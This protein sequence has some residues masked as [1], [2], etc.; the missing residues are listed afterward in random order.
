MKQRI[1]SLRAMPQWASFR[2]VAFRL[3]PLI[4]L[5]VAL[6]VMI[7]GPVSV[8]AQGGPELEL[9]KT[10]FKS[11]VES[12]EPFEYVFNYRCA[13]ISDDCEGAVITDPLPPEVEFV[14][15]TLTVT[16]HVASYG[17]D[18]GTHTV[19]WTFVDPL[20]A[21]ST[22]ILKFQV[23]FPPGT[24]P[25]TTA[26][27]TATFSASNAVSVATSPIST[28]AT[29]AFEMYAAKSGGPAVVGFPA[30]FDLQVCSPDVEGGV[31]YTAPTMIDHLPDDAAFVDAEGSQCPGNSPPGPGD[32]ECW[33]YDSTATPRTV[34]WYNL[35]DITVGACFTR[36]I[37]LQYD[38][39]PAG[40]QTNSMETIGTPEGCQDQN[41]LPD[42]C[43]GQ[44][45]AILTDTLPFDVI[46]PY[47]AGESGKTS[48]SPSSYEG[49]EAIPGEDV[50]YEVSVVNTGYED[51]HN[52]VVTDTL[53]S[54]TILLSLT[55]GPASAPGD[56]VNGY[57]Q[58]DDSGNW[59]PL[60][61]NP[62][63]AESTIDATT[64]DLQG[65]NR[66]TDLQWQ[67]GTL[68]I[69]ASWAS[70]VIAEVDTTI[71][72][73]YP[74]ESFENCTGFTSDN[75]VESNACSAVS[76]IDERAI[77]RPRKTSGGQSVLPEGFVDFSVGLNN[78]AVAQLPLDNPM[79]VDLLPPEFDYVA[80]SASV[81]SKPAGAPDPNF[82]VIP[83]Y[84]GTGRTLLRWTWQD[85]TGGGCDPNS[86]EGTCG[87]DASYSFQPGEDA[88][89]TFTVQVKKGTPP[90]TVTNEATIVDWTGP[91]DPDDPPNS[92]LRKIFLCQD[93]DKYV[94]VNDL[95]GDGNTFEESCL[96]TE[97]T[98]VGVFLSMDSEKWVRGEI[99]CDTYNDPAVCDDL[100]VGGQYAGDFNKLGLTMPGERVDYLVQT[101][102]NSNV[103]VT[104]LSFLDITPYIGD[105]GVIDLS[106]RLSK[107]R[108]NL[109]EEVVDLV[110]GI[111]FT[112]FYSRASNPCRPDFVPSLDE[113]PNCQKPY[114]S[115]TL[116]QNPSSVQSI[117]VDFCTYN[118]DGTVNECLVLQPDETLRFG[119]HM[120]APADAPGDPSCLTPADDSFDPDANPDCQ[121]AWNSFGF[122]AVEFRDQDNDGQ[123]DP[124]HL[125]LLPSEPLKVGIRVA[126]L[127][128]NSLGDYTWL[129][130]AGIENDGIQQ[131]VEQQA[132]WGVNGVRVELWNADTDAFIDY[133]ITGPDQDGKPG[134]Y[135]FTDLPDGN[136]YLRF[137]P[138]SGYTASPPNQGG[139]DNLDSDGE[140]PGTDATYGDYYQT[141]DIS[142]T[143]NVDDRS[144]D[145]GMYRPTD[146][147]DA[148][149]DNATDFYPTNAR[150]LANAGL[151]PAD[152]ARH[153][154]KNN[155]HMGATV[156][157]EDDGF[158]EI[159][160]WG[161]DQNQTPDDE[162]GVTFDQ[163]LG[164]PELPSA[165][166]VIGETSTWNVT[167]TV[168]DNIIL[169]DAYLNAWLDFNGDGDWNDAGEQIAADV[170]AA[171]GTT[172][173]VLTL[174]IPVPAG[175]TPGTTHARFRL[176]YKQGLGPT[177]AVNYGEVEDYQVQLINKPEKNLVTTSEAHTT[178]P[179][180]TIGEIVRYKLTVSVPEGDLTNF[181][182]TDTLP[183]GLQFLDDN[184]AALS[185][186]SD[187]AMTSTEFTISGGPFADGVDPIFT[188]GT[189]T[190]SDQDD[191]EEFVVIEFNALVL[192]VSGNAAGDTLDNSFRVTFDS[193]D[194]TS[195]PVT[196]NLVEP[197]VSIVKTVTTLPPID[198][199]D[200]VTYQLT[201]TND[202]AAST[203]FDLA[204]D[205]ILDANLDLTDPNNVT[206]TAPAY[207]AVTNNSDATA[208]EV[209]LLIDKLEPGDQVTILITVT[210][211]TSVSA[212][213][214][215]PN[216]ADLAYTS[217]PGP[218]GTTGNPTGSDTPG[219]TD[220]E[221][222]ERLYGPSDSEDI[223]I[224]SPQ[225]DKL[226]PSP[227][228]YA[229]GE[230]ISYYIKVTL[231]EGTTLDMVVVD[232]LPLGLEYQSHQIITTAA[233]SGGRLGDDFNG[234]LPT[235]TVT[236]PGGSG[237]DVT[238]NFGN[239]V[240]TA[241]NNAGNNSF[242]IEIIARVL[243]IPDNS[244]GDVRDNI[245]KLQY[246]NPNNQQTE[247]IT[248]TVA[249][250]I[251]EPFL[252]ITKEVISQ[253]DPIGP[254]GQIKYR[255]TIEH[256][257]DSAMD[258]YGVIMTDTLP[259]SLTNVQVTSMSP[260]LLTWSYDPVT[261]VLRIPD[262]GSFDI[263]LGT[264]YV[265]EYTADIT[266][267]LDA[268][269]SIDNNA[270]ITWTS[271][272]GDFP[273]REREY[274]D[275]DVAP[276][277]VDGEFGDLPDGPYPTLSANNG[278]RH[279]IPSGANPYFLGAAVDA[280]PDGQPNAAATG[281]DDNP[282]SGTDDED[283][284]TFL[285]PII[286]GQPANVQIVANADGYLHGWFDFD[287]DGVLDD[288]LITAVDGVALGSPTAMRDYPVTAG[289][290]IY[291]FDAP[292]NTT[293]LDPIYSR[294]RFTSY[295][296]A[297]DPPNDPPG[298]LGPDGL[299]LDGEVE[300]YVLM[301]LGNYVWFDE[302]GNGVQDAG[303]PP[304]QDVLVN[305]LDS[306]GNPVT[307]AAGAPIVTTTDANGYYNFGG[308]P[309]G[310]YIVEVDAS[311]WDAGNVFGAGGLYPDAY[312]SPGQGGDD[313]DNTDDNGDNDGAAAIGAGVRSAPINLSPGQEPVDED[314]QETTSN[315]NSDL[316]IDFGFTLPVSVGSLVWRDDNAN[317]IQDA[318]EPPIEGATVT[319]LDAA[320]NSV[321]T[322]IN[323]N[324]ITPVT[325]G[326]DGVYHFTDL[327]QGEYIIQVQ[328]PAGMKPTPPQTPDPD[329]DDNADSNI[330]AETSPG[331]YRSDPVTLSIGGEPT[332]ETF[333]DGSPDQDGKRDDS[334]N[335]TVDFGFVQPV[336]IGSLVWLDS[337]LDGVQDVGESPIE[338]AIVT[339]LDS[340]GNPVTQDLD[341]NAIS[342]VTTAADG[343][344]NFSNLPPGDYQ[345]Q[346]QPPAGFRPTPVQQTN[347]NDDVNTDSNIA[348]EPNPGV[349]VSGIVSLLGGTE[350]TGET[351]ADGSPDQDG[352]PDADG[353]MTVDFGFIRPVSVG[354][355]VW[356]DLNANGLQD[357]G[358][359]GVD[360]ATVTLLDSSGAPVT[361]DVDGN[362]INPITTGPDG[363]YHFVNLPPGDYMVEVQPPAGYLPTPPQVADPNTDDNA[364]SN[365]ATEPS[366]G[367]YRSGVVSLLPGA[368][369][370]GE[371]FADGSPDQ[372]GNPDAD[373]NMTLDFG[374]IRPVSLGSLVWHDANGNGVQDAGEPGIE[375]AT[376]HLLDSAGNPVNDVNGNPVA[377]VTTGPDGVYHF[378]N[379]MPGDYMVEVTPPA[380]Y[381]PTSP[382]VTN[383]NND[384][385]ADSNI[386]TEPTP[387]V[388]RSDLITLSPGTE[389]VDETF[390]DGGPDQ[391]GNPDADGNMTLDF[392]F[393]EPVS[394]GS[395]VWSD[396]NANGLQDVG[397]PGIENATVSL[398]NAD[399]TPANDIDGNPVADVT[400]GTDGVYHFTN[401][402][403][404]DYI[405]QVTPPAGL[406]PTSPQVA[407]PNN[408]DNADSNIATESSP[409][410][411][412][413]GVVTLVNG[414]E[415]T[416]ETFADGSPDQ[417]GNPD[418]D[419]NMTVD[420][421]F[422]EP[423]SVGSL[424]WLDLNA[425]GLQDDGEPGVENATVSLVDAA[426]NP[427]TDIDGNPVAD[428]TTGPDGVYH[429]TNLAPGDYR[430]RVTPPAGFI[431]TPP[432]VAD[433][434]NDDNADSNIATEPSPGQYESGS[435]TLTVGG[436]PT[437]ELFAD[438][439]PD[440]DGNPDASGN[441]TV[442][443]GFI[444]PVSLGSFVW[445]DSNGN[446]VQDA[447][448]P[449]IEN[450]TVRLLDSAGNPVNDVN[451]N[452]VADVTTGPDGVYHFVN[453]PPGDYMVEV[454][455][456]AGYSPTSP[457]VTNP[458]NDD[459]ADSNI[460]TE[461]SAGVYRSGVVS[462][463]PGA[464]PT[465][466]TFADGGPDQDGNPDADGNM[467][468]DFGFIEPVSLG[469][470]VWLDENAN[471]IQDAG[472][473]P[474]ENATV[475]LLFSDG[476]PATDM[477]GNPVA[478]V[479][480][481]TDGVYHF[482][483]LAPGDYIVQVTPPPGYAPT[484]SQTA[485]PNTDD[486]SDSN[487][488]DEPTPGVYAS[489]VVTLTVGGEPT[490][491]LF[492]DGSPDQDG[493]PDADGNMTVDFGFVEV[494]SVGSLV[495]QDDNNNGIQDAG[496]PPIQGATVILLDGAGNPITQDA[497]G[498]PINPVTTG[499]DGV[500]NFANLPPGDYII[501]VS[502]PAG[503]TPSAVQ[504]PDP[505]TDD[506]TD[507]NIADEPNPGEFRSGVVTLSVGGEPT[508][509]NF[510]DGSPDQDGN[511]DDSGNMTVDFGFVPTANLGSLGDLVWWDKNH[512][513]IQDAG[514]PGIEGVALTL[515]DGVT[516]HATTDA[517]GVYTFTDLVADVYTVTVDASNFQAGGPLANWTPSPAKVGSDDAVDSDG[518]ETT[519]DYSVTL[520]AG[521][522]NP[523]IDFG[524]YVT[525]S[526]TLT[527]K[528]NTQG[529]IR[530][531]DPISFT[532]AITNTGGSWLAVLPLTDTYDTTYL[533]YGANGNYA[534][535]PSDD[536]ND[537]GQ[538]DWSDLTAQVGDIAP[539]DTVTV[540]VWFTT[541]ADT[542]N[543]PDGLTLNTA[544]ASGVMADADGPNGPL[545]PDES[546]DAIQGQTSG[547]APVVILKP[548]GLFVVDFS[549]EVEDRDVTLNWE[550]VSELNILGFQVLRQE[551]LGAKA[552]VVQEAFVPARWS[553]MDHGGEYGI[554]AADLAPGVY[555]YILQAV[556]MDG[557]IVNEG[558][559][560]ITI[561]SGRAAHR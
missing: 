407:D 21:G 476:S 113:P 93:P 546:L 514:E 377:D 500:Y 91:T 540:T 383:P 294:F 479:T 22:G 44:T 254:G 64:L 238:F 297:S 487:I 458:N 267:D 379:L 169:G 310:D 1:R 112:V 396:L 49:T 138:P 10:A 179:D 337:N 440:Q 18:P 2:S 123:N 305:L 343:L 154:L 442:D 385:N 389:P 71:E 437:G 421:G 393:I 174:N 30:T 57:Y 199:G 559:V 257:A 284:V 221:T 288:I 78:D 429:F 502:P 358:E 404:G 20:P 150:D 146:Y 519:H 111:P 231:P 484:P 545:P 97:T 356:L 43:D 141:A 302:N 380:G 534:N 232:D 17:Y 507:S 226:D 323:G 430:V 444:R 411:Y 560:R 418:A 67:L 152:A 220:A 102:N 211:R 151:E 373:G 36:Q 191:N 26:T 341:G 522:N 473:T 468:V 227:T 155:L 281:D 357:D 137:F 278:A 101:I 209:H 69:G 73:S 240:T 163:Y 322:D 446:G 309:P 110:G 82:E 506:N 217:L 63:A 395:L 324:A 196:V 255:V 467:T 39:L 233:A 551:G 178:D 428:V 230:D 427:V 544:T 273:G 471:G 451:G 465:G 245:G 371:T 495:W 180:L 438:G 420:F 314:P 132:A 164:T 557:R 168:P 478:D 165:I 450:A 561:R 325:T 541:L 474:V 266:S 553:G 307:D 48:S 441:M 37:K 253:S 282:A 58:V 329:N 192:N 42:Y 167:V 166:M 201:L 301:S 210:V 103:P 246:T 35:P 55:I 511:R 372:D 340:A 235:P 552:E 492:A 533:S 303:E 99:D 153:V 203:A 381:S 413:S 362:P 170:V 405:V 485:D 525:S 319:L 521:E 239:T 247:T 489:G 464:E 295:E 409:G 336:S 363:I 248:D 228:D 256:T 251:I 463:L 85:L 81:T 480:T 109:Q 321:T 426:G 308:L 126:P 206:W 38:T 453:L 193:F 136:Y 242:L 286:P 422:I 510:A 490:G 543:E 365:I 23:R 90:G 401:L 259:A 148:P 96:A 481:G 542:G 204:V 185:F 135:Q 263:P 292:A 84:N 260:S 439:S 550:T 215:I 33:V 207:A 352:N 252:N 7:T 159:S 222:G 177:G 145:F 537:D 265:I 330:A 95:D 142:L 200:E 181:V 218:N 106:P 556:L 347:P 338:G 299:A 332:G 61:G 108:P 25:G 434:N 46:E 496:E 173:G 461:P 547:D 482:T 403:P 397:E 415:P 524:F 121:I 386:A 140:I 455:P 539:G 423:V 312:G 75:G 388:Y 118:T 361:Q 3:I 14:P 348:S 387:G 149:F 12:G 398:L 172:D 65:G 189:V 342:P 435:V 425:N 8:S 50:T 59:I 127:R 272:D 469:S 289:S 472:E 144:W 264:T 285:T 162:D 45:E 77:P 176:S 509:E 313:Q 171:Q 504:Q 115:T 72:P 419:G 535:P 355:L 160:A 270:V 517:N 80:G 436:E 394:L 70:T 51:L 236:A 391:D 214:I 87:V 536:N 187:N 122:K 412:R 234:A 41:N 402:A 197:A 456:P 28:T 40:Q 83:D 306:A 98:E 32:P 54:Q 120:T 293:T 34:S 326:A 335:M 208:D 86:I 400:T 194:Y 529:D 271:M 378:T 493:N 549:A 224:D 276:V 368:E 382:Q 304:I 316:T 29:G 349:Y 243:D 345:V 62:Y 24:V 143:G 52:V 16:P 119:W 269:G 460:A 13:S 454:T 198:A 296:T 333:A 258:A 213:E 157:G 53:P 390:A 462:L 250:N 74:A 351:F 512:D 190:N 374:F 392:G 175:A 508:G 156:D 523:N 470:L 475:S 416:G 486:N 432:Q 66:I 497:S 531:G 279:L 558:S 317:G 483:N 364:D 68:A 131:P 31:N 448:E 339:L 554:T 223:T 366:A 244:N 15:D 261:G 344:Y 331:V 182:I 408:D 76:V 104:A 375:N 212:G 268:G 518:D 515:T 466:E 494:V 124:D 350:P 327:P 237:G 47:P 424:V 94:D 19:T 116:P 195:A 79:L 503:F 9:T 491:E 6:G 501:Q 433:P 158:P 4:V 406:N 205:D 457:Q 320:G 133:K 241:D 27:N 147:S 445:Q 360:G 367:V 505:N 528:L 283:G 100:S 354:S 139:D 370:T 128:R 291:T 60:P 300:D 376:V 538:I 516:L 216:T 5:L 89:I 477:D 277:Q 452:P 417:D 262:T 88:N 134:Y 532:I 431:P 443:F 11:E 513:G 183:A 202:G 384:D 225:V 488:A 414:Q 499:S 346:V 526:Y 318:G 311:N 459:N 275:N 161:D 520:G 449:G 334:G 107:W 353:N 447:G 125:E 274:T 548:T 498:N 219:A 530:V 290:H 186:I 280:E 298:I 188:L 369:P 92:D 410:V 527:K 287:A 114:W 129:D 184:T 229:I 359:P 315:A 555:R 130:V 56:A 105:T 117:K 249:I 328:P 399:G